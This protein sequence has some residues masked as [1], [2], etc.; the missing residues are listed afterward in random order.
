ML[1][2]NSNLHIESQYP[3]NLGCA[4]LRVNNAFDSK[5]GTEISVENPVPM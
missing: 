2:T 1:L 4:S 3:R 5:K